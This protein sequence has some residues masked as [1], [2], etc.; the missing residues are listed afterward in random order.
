MWA[1]ENSA[2]LKKTT[3]TTP[4]ETEQEGDLSS[5]GI[6]MPDAGFGGDF[7]GEELPPEGEEAPPEGGA[8]PAGGAEPAA[9]AAPE[10]GGPPL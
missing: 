7:G 2:K 10:G 1:E 6:R 9:A 8:P 5:V 3:G 4:A